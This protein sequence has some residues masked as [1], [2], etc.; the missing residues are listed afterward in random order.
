MSDTQAHPLTVGDRVQHRRT[1]QAGTVTAV[2]PWYA[3][4]RFDGDRNAVWESQDA[5][6]RAEVQDKRDG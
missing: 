5:L 3:H 2:S 4:V 1:K 6:I